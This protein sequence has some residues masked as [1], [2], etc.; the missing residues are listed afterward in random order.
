MRIADLAC[1]T[2]ADP[3]V[4]MRDWDSSPSDRPSSTVWRLKSSSCYVALSNSAALDSQSG[5]GMSSIL[6]RR[7]HAFRNHVSFVVDRKRYR[8]LKPRAPR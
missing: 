7:P 2:D 5:S 1:F 3:F 4:T 6:Q 8:A